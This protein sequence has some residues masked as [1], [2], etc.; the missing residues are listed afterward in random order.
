MTPHHPVVACD[1][2]RFHH[3]CI[4][5][6][7]RIWL[8]PVADPLTPLTPRSHWGRFRLLGVVVVVRV[9]RVVASAR[10]AP[11]PAALLLY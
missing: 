9:V 2:C 4:A 11:D 10:V 8:L 5:S 6:S 1:F 3:D 7:I